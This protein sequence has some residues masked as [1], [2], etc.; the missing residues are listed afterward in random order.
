[1]RLALISDVHA[2]LPALQ[3]VLEDIRRKKI[4][5]IYCA[6]DLVGDGPFPSEV[7]KLLRKYKVT[8][9]RG[10]S[11]LKIL[12]ARKARKKRREPLAKWT[13][14]QLTVAD[15]NQLEKLPAQRQIQVDGKKI[16]LVHG[17]PFSEV[18]YITP[19]RKSQELEE[20]LVE[21][22]CQ[23]LICGHSHESFVR[24]L[25]SGWVINCGAVGKHAN[26][27]GLAQYAVLSI[28]HGKVQATIEE[29]AYRRERL[30]R[31]AVDRKFPLDEE[32]VI[33]SL[34]ALRDSPQMFR[35][36]VISAQ[37]S[38][39][40]SFM[41][42]FETAEG[43]LKPA[44]VR[45]LRITAMKL[46]HA[47]RTFSAYYPAE[48]LHLDEIK[49]IR[50]YAGELRELDVLMK[51]LYSHRRLQ[52]T[53][54][55]G[56]PVLIDEIANEREAAQSRLAQ[57]LHRSRQHRLFDELQDT[58]DYHIRRRP[59]RQS[60]V[61][62]SQGTFANTRRLL[63]KVA[64]TA[65]HRLESAR[66]PLAREEFHRLRVTC[67]KLRYTLEIFESVGSG[68]FKTELKKLRD[69]QKLMG[70]IHDLDTCTD[71]I[72]NLRSALRG[73]L[74]PAELRITDSLVQLF[75]RNR[76]HLF[77]QCLKASYEF[78]N[79]RFFQS[80]VPNLAPNTPSNGNRQRRK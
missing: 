21:A 77:E 70:R 5:R 49:K 64:G 72:I 16:L 4:R 22:G 51:E 10:N 8:A 25:K 32:S 39:L 29:V 54:P 20:M 33:T 28:N 66:N 30:F 71:R 42:A 41:K 58:L 78:E 60:G 18:E 6:G 73:R 76:M 17:S 40:R 13:L 56:F 12:K 3:S 62:P 74:T 45:Q 80:L 26:G 46:L 63:K 59:V 69:F 61:D 19:Q 47:L 55:A 15:L 48:R 1:M 68:D 24:Q 50:K 57:V 67:K 38:L 36:E 27:T 43:D 65:I 34:S 9:I 23:I 79:S 14:K 35:R 2:N 53:E 31:A 75:Q 44:N 7:L 11:D 37:R 52:Q